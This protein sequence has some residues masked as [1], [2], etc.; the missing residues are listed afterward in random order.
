[1]NQIVLKWLFSKEIGAV[2]E[3]SSNEGMKEQFES[4]NLELNEEDLKKVKGLNKNYRILTYGEFF[5][6][7]MNI[8]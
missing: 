6:D 8:F 1:M 5:Q 7:E 4:W 3:S 2:I